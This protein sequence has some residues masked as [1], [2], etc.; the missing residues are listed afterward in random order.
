MRLP[1]APNHLPGEAGYPAAL[2]DL[3]PAPAIRV[4]GELPPLDRAVA[5]VG[6]RRADTAAL[7]H[8]HALAADLVRSGC[9]VLSGG[10]HGIDAAAHEG[11]LDAGGRTVA[12]LATGLLHPYPSAHGE[13]FE[14]IAASGAV[15]TEAEDDAVPH[16][17][18]FLQRNRLVAALARVVV[19]VQAPIP[20]GALSTAA[21]AKRLDRPLLAVPAAPWDRRGQGCL[22][23][24][25]AGARICTSARDVLSV[26]AFDGPSAQAGRPSGRPHLGEKRNDLADL[27]P[28]TR[29]VLASVGS[30]PHH[31]DELVR[32]SRLPVPRVHR[33]LLMLT[34]LGFVEEPDPG[35]YV[36]RR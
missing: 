1:P 35:R 5:I 25:A 21:W 7:E 26:A 30:R 19:V 17:Y 31:V 20:S 33:A 32:Q 15:L 29:A 9:A 13:L 34:L 23:L 27:D 14:R 16:R 6:T 22:A 11:A 18:L 2:A 24:L 4:A 8:A 36:R 12:I 10:A 3:D 28:D